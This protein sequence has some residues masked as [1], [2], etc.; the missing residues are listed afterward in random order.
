MINQGISWVSC[1][2]ASCSLQIHCV[3]STEQGPHETHHCSDPCTQPNPFLL[4][5]KTVYTLKK[6][7][8]PVKNVFVGLHSSSLLIKPY[9][10]LSFSRQAFKA[11]VAEQRFAGFGMLWE[12]GL[13]AGLWAG[14]NMG[15]GEESCFCT[16]G[17]VQEAEPGIKK[18]PRKFFLAFN[19]ADEW[20]RAESYLTEII[21]LRFVLASLG[22]RSWGT[23]TL[24]DWG[25]ISFC[26]AGFLPCCSE[27]RKDLSYWQLWP[28]DVSKPPATF[29]IHHSPPRME[30]NLWNGVS[31]PE[32]PLCSWF[33]S[34]NDWQGNR[35]GLEA[36]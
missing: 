5:L 26:P 24:W 22:M 31:H 35:S 9:M 15:L 25:T 14:W 29:H 32:N 1:N 6:N 23:G 19:A 30:K 20:C 16:A 36:Q 2:I 13:V 18:R 4:H 27:V 8:F 10:I 7:R 34:H 33:L 28:D 21:C 17:K 3:F 12:R 11:L